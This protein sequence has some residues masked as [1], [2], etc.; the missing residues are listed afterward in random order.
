MNRACKIR[1]H[2]ERAQIYITEVS[3]ENGDFELETNDP[4][5]F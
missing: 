1:A 2:I 3:D 5:G 4:L